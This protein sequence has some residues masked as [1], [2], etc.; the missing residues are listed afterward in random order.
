MK[1]IQF[2]IAILL[3][4]GFSQAAFAQLK[5]ETIKVAGEC[6]TCKKKIET[7]A[8]SAGATYASWSADTKQLN[9]KYNAKTSNTAKI[10]QAV[11]KAGYD[12]PDYK[13]TDAAYKKLDACCQYE[14]E[15][16]TVTSTDQHQ[17][18]AGKDQ[19]CCTEGGS[20]CSQCHNC[21]TKGADSCCTEG[22][23]C[24]AS[25]NNCCAEGNSAK[26]G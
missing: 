2:A 23:T 25:C 14:R 19:T 9:V 12:T 17:A 6:G 21:C 24:C 22:H 13:A 15:T 8:K 5:T 3:T 20:C 4:I 26:K 10:E 7:A 16:V 1:K 18:K 11:A